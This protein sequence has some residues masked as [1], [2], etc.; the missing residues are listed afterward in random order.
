MQGRICSFLVQFVWPWP[1]LGAGRH[2][3]CCQSVCSTV[4]GGV[5]LS[6]VVVVLVV[7]VETGCTRLSVKLMFFAPPARSFDL[8]LTL[9]SFAANRR[10]A[11]SMRDPALLWH[12]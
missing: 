2:W 8:R 6:L 10:V 1:T 5:I 11:L 9:L 4:P 3:L 12:F 7:L